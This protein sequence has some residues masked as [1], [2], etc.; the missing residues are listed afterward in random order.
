MGG[1]LPLMFNC[2]IAPG[3]YSSRA[4]G[5][6]YGA[7][8]LGAASGIVAAPFLLLNHF[9]IPVTL[10]GVGVA[11]ILFG[12][13]LYLFGGR[14]ESLPPPAQVTKPAPSTRPPRLLLLGLAAASG[15]AVLSFEIALFREFA[16]WNPSSPYTFPVVLMPVLLSLAAGS[17]LFTRFRVY[18]DVACVHRVG[19]LFL[20]AAAGLVA[21]LGIA[22]GLAHSGV[23]VSFNDWRHGYFFFYWLALTVPVPLFAGGVFPLLL[24]LASGDGEELPA[25]TGRIYLANAVGAF[26]GALLTQFAGFPLLGTKGLIWTVLLI[27]LGAGV[28]ALA[29]TAKP[30]LRLATVLAAVLAVLPLLAPNQLW[31]VYVWG[32]R[33]EDVDAVEGVTGVA[34]I[35]W[36]DNGSIG[37]VNVNGQLMSGLPDDP[38]HLRLSSFVLALEQPTRILVLGLGG[39]GTVREIVE[40]HRVRRVDVV[41]WSYEL[42]RLL[43]TPRAR[44]IL[45]GALEDPKVRIFRCD[46]RVAVALYADDSFDVIVD[47]LARGDW[48]G[49]TTVKSSQFYREVKRLLGDGGVF[50]YDANFSDQDQRRA[51]LAALLANFAFVYEHDSV[52][53]LASDDPLGIVS[54]RAARALAP[55]AAAI[56]IEGDPAAWM[57]DGLRLVTARDVG[58]ARPVR[59]DLLVHEFNRYPLRY[60]LPH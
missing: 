50:V 56:G 49:A 38:K 25:S 28:S 52:L 34:T 45:R 14:R 59:D 6:I 43:A 44:S 27:N 29:R 55:R 8:T 42:P 48:V 46:A 13:F 58:N 40:D 15:F 31:A 26:A 39:G 5:V 32:T 47:N 7:N 1:T 19:F 18:S 17:V 30:R 20:G 54:A 12:I 21:G 9:S 53:V 10:S 37:E 11:N 3:R 4:V 41:D 22:S 60:L 16:L 23:R 36:S 35:E 33:A 51:N 24:R 2:F 57:L